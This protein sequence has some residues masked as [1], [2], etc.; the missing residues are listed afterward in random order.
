MEMNDDRALNKSKSPVYHISWRISSHT[1]NWDDVQ[2]SVM[3]HKYTLF[4]NS[5]P[6][7]TFFNYLK[8]MHDEQLT[9]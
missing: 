2:I 1:L 9:N 7:Q 5:R 3:A 4:D 8:Q 6:V